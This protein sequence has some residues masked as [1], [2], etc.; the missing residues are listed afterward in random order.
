M[1]VVF[2]VYADWYVEFLR[3]VQLLVEIPLNRRLTQPPLCVPA[4]RRRSC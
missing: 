4:H 2:H 3:I 1:S